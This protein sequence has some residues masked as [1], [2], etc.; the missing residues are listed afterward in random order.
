MNKEVNKAPIV[1]FIRYSQKVKFGNQKTERDMFEPEYFEYRFN[2]FK[3][4]TLKSFQQQT[5]QNFVILLLHSESM[6]YHY[7]QKFMELENENTFLY[8]IFLKDNQDSFDEA[9]IN[10]ADYVAFKENIAVTFRIDND[11]AVQND[12]VEK[13]SVL[14]KSDFVGYAVSIPML[15]IV[16][17]IGV[18]S[19]LLQEFY[20]PANAI[21]LAHITS[22]DQYKT[23]FNLGDHDLINNKNALIL[24]E[25]YTN[26]G[27]MTIN[28][29]NAINT[30]DETK[31]KIYN[32]TDLYHYLK[33][34]KIEN[35]NLECLRIF[36]K[37]NSISFKKIQKLFI[38]PI[39][40][41]IE[42]KIKSIF[43]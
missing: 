42:Q 12:F 36:E 20:F 39:V 28:G 35:I 24:F 32:K 43:R 16:K 37:E 9:I 34:K 3:S 5:N 7:K 10:S 2:I 15:Y 38:P 1:G 30:M 22:K 23:I 6:P 33:E 25:S 40:N 11:D 14:L 13:L 41:I 4:V 17:R 27:L 29:E 19:Y 26:G 8:N 18:E 31:A 21:G